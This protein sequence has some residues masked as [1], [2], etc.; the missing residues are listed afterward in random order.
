MVETCMD[1]IP[2][3]PGERGN[4]SSGVNWSIRPRPDSDGRYGRLQAVDLETRKVV[5]LD[6]QRAPQSTCTLATAGGVVFAGALDRFLSAYDAHTGA[7]LWRARLADVPSNCPISYSVGGKQYVAV[8]VGNGGS[9]S[10]TFSVLVP[11]IQNPPV[12]AGAVWVFELP[13][14]ATGVAA[15]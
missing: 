8:V 13:D 4:L 7:T 11:E 12:H 3:A 1:L 14:A 9:M 2:A 15:R 6:R 10:Q 5:W